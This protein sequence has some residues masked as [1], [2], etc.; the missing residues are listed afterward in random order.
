MRLPKKRIILYVGGVI[1][2]IATITGFSLLGFS[3]ESVDYNQ[4]GLK[5]NNLTK[6]IETTVYREGL[7]FIGFWYDFITFPS[8]YTTIEF[9]PDPDASDIPINVQTK[10]G[11]LVKID[12]SFQFRIRQ[13]DLLA[14]YSN[15]GMGYLD[16]IEAEAR[17]AL[18]E[19]VGN[20]EAE[21][22]YA[23]RSLVN[24]DMS[25][26]LFSSLSSIVDV[27]NF[28]LRHINFPDSFEEAV[29]QYEVWRVEVE[30]AQLEQ[31]AEIIRQETEKLITEYAAN[32]TIIEYEGIAEALNQL[33][34]TLN[35]TNSELLQYLWIE[36]IE[37]HDQSYLFIGMDT[38]ILL[39]LNTTSSN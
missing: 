28:Q 8:T 4:Y 35:M 17:S 30:I 1:I 7:Y 32:N 14:L 5:Q 37:T 19:V 11:L 27:G 31:E 3:F 21:T 18:R 29:E 2:L 10:N 24:A 15:Y 26:A 33:Q 25:D 6:Q 12:L 9:T 34:E 20:F 39:P 22:L 38:P 13:T 16:Y 23:N 36:T